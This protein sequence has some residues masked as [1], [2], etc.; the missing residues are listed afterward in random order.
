M[1]NALV[2]ENILTYDQRQWAVIEILQNLH[3]R[4]KGYKAEPESNSFLQKYF[5][6]KS[7]EKTKGLYIY[8]NVGTG[9]TMLMDLFYFCVD[10][11]TKLYGG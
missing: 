2:K 8:G 11:H 7:E 1:Y 5:T 10:A 4:L 9:K 6:S 3:T